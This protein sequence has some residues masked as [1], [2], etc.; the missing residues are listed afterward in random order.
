MA[1]QLNG[2]TATSYGTKMV[3]C[4]ARM[5][6]PSYGE[7]VH[8]SGIL[9][10]SYIEKTAQQLNG[11]MAARN[12]TKTANRTALAA[13]QLHLRVDAAGG[14][15]LEGAAVDRNALDA[16]L[17]A[18][19]ARDPDLQLVLRSDDD[20]DYQGFVAALSASRAA[21]VHAIATTR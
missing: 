1:P 9:T 11:A 8:A 17:R 3:N 20:G 19:V 21:G 7:V 2:P 10:A 14:Y 18:A 6:L 12:G 15:W 4:I 16:A 5:G 13:P